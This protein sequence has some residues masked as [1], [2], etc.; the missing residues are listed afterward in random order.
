MK[1]EICYEIIY[2]LTAH[3]MFVSLVHWKN[4]PPV[5]LTVSWEILPYTFIFGSLL[6]VYWTYAATCGCIT[7]YSLTFA[8]LV[9][10][11]FPP[12]R[13][14]HVYDKFCVGPDITYW[15]SQCL[16]IAFALRL[17]HCWD[18][19]SQ[20]IPGHPKVKNRFLSAKWPQKRPLGRADFFFYFFFFFL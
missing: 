1:S 10:K 12:L 16:I 3:A 8:D 2:P 13:Y 19:L 11:V 4:L 18:I 20:S 15:A 5:R 14:S 9:D 7:S 6:S 17:H